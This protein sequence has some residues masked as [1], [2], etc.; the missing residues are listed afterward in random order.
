MTA[1]FIYEKLLRKETRVQNRARQGVNDQSGLRL[2][3]VDAGAARHCPS[4]PGRRRL[5]SFSRGGGE[6]GKSDVGSSSET[7]AG[8][9]LT[10]VSAG[11]HPDAA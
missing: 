4:W 5:S 7:P 2:P 3:T 6:G 10:V 1:V 9:V 11:D 8:G